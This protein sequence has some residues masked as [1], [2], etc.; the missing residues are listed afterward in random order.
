MTRT[1][2]LLT[3]LETPLQT[4]LPQ[5]PSP[6]QP[7]AQT[8]QTLLPRPLRVLLAMLAVMAAAA[9][10]ACVQAQAHASARPVVRQDLVVLQ[11]TAEQFLL[12]QAAMQPGSVSVRVTPPDNRLHL[13]RCDALQAYL[14]SGARALGKTTVGVRC[15]APVTWHVHLPATVSVTVGYVASAAPLA[16]GQ[17]LGGAHLVLRQGDLATLPAGVLTD[18]AQA[19][20]RA[21]QW[22]VIAG[23]PLSQA[24]LKTIPVVQSGQPV[25]LVAQGPGFSVSGEGRALGT[26]GAGDLVQARTPNGQ[27]IGGIAQADGTLLVGY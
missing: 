6:L 4:R 15:M 17:R 8:M 24:M 7:A 13:A 9:M 19:Q 1:R 14:A 11:Q 10:P 27:V 18:P 21:L 5:R 12:A 22:S 26:G 16:A 20:G 25:R 23:T 3:P 2:H